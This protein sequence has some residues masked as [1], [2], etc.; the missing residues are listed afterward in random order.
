MSLGPVEH[1]L[2]EL[3]H[4]WAR[5][6]QGHDRERLE[7]IVGREFT[8][9]GRSD[10]KSREEWLDDWSGPYVIDDWRYEEIEIELYGNT[11]VLSSRYSQTAR[12][13]GDDR[14]GS[15]LVTDV[16]V[17][18]DGRWQVVRRHATLAAPAP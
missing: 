3:A 9:V 16:W 18:R 6:V 4:V 10:E 8:L 17:R 11:A 7:S 13:D 2:V 12:H 15:Y 14:S 1:E 5:A